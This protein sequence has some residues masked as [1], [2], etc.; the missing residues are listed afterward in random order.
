LTYKD[1]FVGLF[2][3]EIVSDFF[4]GL[5]SIFNSSVLSSFFQAFFEPKLDS[6]QV[7]NKTVFSV[8]IS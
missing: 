1:E 6:S 2:G 5:E 7:P 4:L 3:L 8:D